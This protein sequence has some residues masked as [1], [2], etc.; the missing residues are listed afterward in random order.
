[1]DCI[2]CCSLTRLAYLEAYGGGCIRTVRS[3]GH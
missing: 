2:V 1:M 3:D